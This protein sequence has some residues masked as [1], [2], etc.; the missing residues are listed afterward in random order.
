ML[1][2]VEEKRRGP[3]NKYFL[4]HGEFSQMY[5]LYFFCLGDVTMSYGIPP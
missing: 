4:R 1:V 3:S 5:S 2:K